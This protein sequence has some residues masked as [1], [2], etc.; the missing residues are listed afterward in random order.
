MFSDIREASRSGREHFMAT[1]VALS[2]GSRTVNTDELSVVEVVDGQQRLTTLTI[3]FKAIE[4][5]LNSDEE[6][7]IK[8]QSDLRRL[9]VKSDDHS[10]VLLQ[11]NH[12]SSNIFG[13]YIRK[14]KIDSSPN[15]TSDKNIID[16]VIECERFVIE[17]T[18]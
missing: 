6:A 14:G 11:T 10:L 18:E 2:R 9:L 4:K 15:T 16:A 12:D 3:L 8:V 7:N 1:V 17:W 13:S 5:S